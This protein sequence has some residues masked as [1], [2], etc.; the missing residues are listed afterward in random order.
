MMKQQHPDRQE[1]LRF[2]L[3]NKTPEHVIRH[4]QA[5]CDTAVK[6]GAAMNRHGYD[7]D[8][9]LVTAAGML[10][11]IARVEDEHW[12][13]GGD[14]VERLGYPQEA[15]IIRAHMFY[16]FSP[17]ESFNETDLVC[18]GDRLVKED[19]YVGL[20]KRIQYVIEKV[21]RTRGSD[22]DVRAKILDKKKQTADL[23]SRIEEI[24]GTTLEQ[25]ME[26]E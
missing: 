8:L 20:E 9:E 25:L 1:C 5:V 11:D 24:I 18:L 15:A 10:H 13:K 6:I 23:I 26:G 4:C 22:P 3:E 21:E 12:I 16:T 2:L 7:F 14:L 19:K 17:I